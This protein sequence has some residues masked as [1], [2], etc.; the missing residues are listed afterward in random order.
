MLPRNL[1]RHKLYVQDLG[2]GTQP[3][4][5]M[6]RK[7]E[8]AH[9]FNFVELCVPAKGHIM[10][11]ILTLNFL[12]KL[13]WQEHPKDPQFF[14]CA[15]SLYSQK[16]KKQSHTLAKTQITQQLIN[17]IWLFS[18]FSQ[19]P[20]L[21]ET[22][23][24]A[25]VMLG[26]LLG[27]KKQNSEVAQLSAAPLSTQYFALLQLINWSFSIKPGCFTRWMAHIIMTVLMGRRRIHFF[28]DF[29]N[30]C[31]SIFWLSNPKS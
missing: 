18:S 13:L 14:W 6:V 26:A 22:N 11:R 21:C 29:H 23:E 12:I 4:R 15:F 30:L 2:K 1:S 7:L 20:N 5:S 24:E 10:T 28:N 16:S 8:M 31:F 9:S 19:E 27:K 3:L 25:A 17:R